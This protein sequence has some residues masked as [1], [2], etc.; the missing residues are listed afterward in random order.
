M[1]DYFVDHIQQQDGFFRSIERKT[2]A[3][4]EKDPQGGLHRANDD[5]GS[6]GLLGAYKVTGNKKYLTAIEKYLTAVFARQK[7]DGLFESSVAGVPVVLNILHEAGPLVQVPSA[8]AD[9]CT[10]ALQALYRA[11]ELC[12]RSLARYGGIIEEPHG[13][14][15]YVC[16]RSGCYALIY[17][18]KE[19]SGISDYLAC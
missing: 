1:A 8:T 10:Q 3:V 11:Q 17:L 14:D 5:L 7:E 4:P 13:N 19:C 15:P 6:L 12:S 2:R 18:L 9:A 16:I